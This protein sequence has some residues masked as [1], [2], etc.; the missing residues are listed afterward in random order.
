MAPRAEISTLVLFPAQYKLPAPWEQG[1]EAE[2]QQ[3][4]LAFAFSKV[5]KDQC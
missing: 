4:E 1:S 5:H 2:L 3:A